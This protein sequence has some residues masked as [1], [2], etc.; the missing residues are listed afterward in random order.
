MKNNKNL[1]NFS[2]FALLVVIV[3][4]LLNIKNI[5]IKLNYIYLFVDERQL[6]DD[7]Y[8]VFFLNDEFQRF[9][10]ID[11]TVYAS[12][13]RSFFDITPDL[14]FILGK[15]SKFSNLFHNLGSGQAMKYCPVLGECI[16][17][18]IMNDENIIN[19]FDYKKFNIKRFSD[20][21]MKDFWNLVQGEENTLHRQGKNSL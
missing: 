12:G 20:D 1:K 4:F 2:H 21:Y 14:R 7:I 5:F 8:N 19:K 11:K 6:I 15:D 9:S 10:N 13:Y 3:V 16:A 18:E 17:E